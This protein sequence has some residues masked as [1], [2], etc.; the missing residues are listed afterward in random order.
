MTVLDYATH[1]HKEE[2]TEEILSVFEEVFKEENMTS[3][4]ELLKKRE[5]FRKVFGKGF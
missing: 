5:A 2:G 3:V 1:V 4:A